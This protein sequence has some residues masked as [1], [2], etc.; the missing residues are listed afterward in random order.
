[1]NRR[2]RTLI[3]AGFLGAVLSGCQMPGSSTEADVSAS[4]PEANSPEPPSLVVP[5]NLS[6]AVVLMPLR[7]FRVEMESGRPPPREMLERAAGASRFEVRDDPATRSAFALLAST[8]QGVLEAL[9][10]WTE[11]GST[12]LV[13][14]DAG[15]DREELSHAVTCRIRENLLNAGIPSFDG[16][17]DGL[18][19]GEMKNGEIE[20]AYLWP[21]SSWL[22]SIRDACAA[23]GWSS[24]QREVLMEAYELYIVDRANRDVGVI[25][26]NLCGRIQCRLDGSARGAEQDFIAS[27]LQH[28]SKH[29]QSQPPCQYMT[30]G[31]Q[32]TLR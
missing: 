27:F 19:V 6:R 5:V 10:T 2:I 3:V 31:P 1:M 14:V 18:W 8:D 16:G 28:W 22:D 13:D 11:S 15:T 7:R 26:V 23:H 21:D 25:N 32:P 30:V 29:P 20:M 9:V 4:N 24:Q 17:I 12:L